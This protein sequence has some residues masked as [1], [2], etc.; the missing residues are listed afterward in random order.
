MTSFFV[1]P[2]QM[3]PALFIFGALLVSIFWR[4][5]TFVVAGLCVVFFAVGVWR[6]QSVQAGIENHILNGYYGEEV[7]VG[8]RVVREPDLREGHTKI[9]VAAETLYV[10]D[11]SVLDISGGAKILLTVKSYPAYVYGDYLRI[12]GKLQMP[13]E[14]EEFNYKKYL[15]AQGIA[16]VMYWPEVGAEDR[17][18]ISQPSAVFEKIMAAKKTFRGAIEQ[19]M[20]PPESSILSAMIFGDQGSGRLSKEWT[21]KLNRSGLRHIT[22][23]SGMNITI[24]SQMLFAL[25]LAIGLWRGQ[26]FYFALLI[27]SIYILTIGAPASAVRAGIMG[28]LFLLAQKVGRPA[29]AG[30]AIVFAA[31]GMVALNPF[32]PTRDVG[33][34]LSFL[35]M[36]GMVYLM[37]SML[38]WFEFIPNPAWLPL[39]QLFAMTLSAQLF[40][41][42]ILIYNF[43]QLS[44]AAPFANVLIVPLLPLITVLGLAYGAAGAIWP[45]F[46]WILSWPAWLFMAYTIAVI[47]FSSRLPLAV[48][49]K[50]VHWI[51]LAGAYTFL[52]WG[53]RR[54]YQKQ[55]LNF[56]LD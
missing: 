21:E 31:T 47:D 46:G 19:N 22:A 14:S 39:R 5:K 23:V 8:G 11:G 25:G 7:S 54:L 3:L 38:G 6:F 10:E 51:W 48:V 20:S 12:T 45:F 4:H 52:A 30:R 26:A 40:T 37:P 53:A 33:F 2:W 13:V 49:I 29:N 16:F 32:L 1:T 36:L 44:L 43:G 15:S 28:G 17:K 34:Q 50:N 35:A 9:T 42:P 41:L 18:K 24:I 27:L 56:L 55:K